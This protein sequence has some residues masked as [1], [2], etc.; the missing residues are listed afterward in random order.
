MLLDADDIPE[1][2][3]PKKLRGTE[4]YA[5][6]ERC[7]ED[8]W[9]TVHP[10]CQ[11]EQEIDGIAL[12]ELEEV[13]MQGTMAERPSHEGN[14]RWNKKSTPPEWSYRLHCQVDER[15]LT[16]CIRFREYEGKPYMVPYTCWA[17]ERKR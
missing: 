14:P 6:I 17:G 11:D 13:I 8:G 15:M 3:W 10:H 7:F 5:T 9:Y 2:P 1:T 12:L 4:I 16:V